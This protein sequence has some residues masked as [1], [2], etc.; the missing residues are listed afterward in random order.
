VPPF[1]SVNE[2]FVELVELLRSHLP[3]VQKLSVEGAYRKSWRTKSVGTKTNYD[4][5]KLGLN[6]TA[7]DDLRL[8]TVARMFPRY[9]GAPC[10]EASNAATIAQWAIAALMIPIIRPTC[11]ATISLAAPQN[12]G[13]AG[14]H[15]HA[16][17]PV[18]A[19]VRAGH[20]TVGG[21]E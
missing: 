1:I 6:W 17:P 14:H 18:R 15:L 3:L 9:A 4:T 8:R 13:R 21:L 2:L 16:V 19:H 12:Q 7:S 5:N 11:A 10:V 20:D